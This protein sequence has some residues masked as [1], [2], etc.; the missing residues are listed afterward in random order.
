MALLDEARRLLG[1]AERLRGPMGNTANTKALLVEP[2]LASLGWDTANVEHVVRDWPLRDDSTVS[3]ALRIHDANAVF[4][5]TRAVSDSLDDYSFEGQTLQRVE[6][7]DA[8]WCVITNGLSYKVFKSNEPVKDD[9]ML[10][11]VDLGEIAQGDIEPATRLGLIGREALIDGSLELR[12]EE[13]FTDPRVREAILML[14]RDPSRTFINAMNEAIG[15][16]SVPV[17]RLRASLGRSFAEHPEVFGGSLALQASPLAGLGRRPPSDGAGPPDQGSGPEAAAESE[18]SEEAEPAGRPEPAE[19]PTPAQEAEPAEEPKPAQE[20]QVEEELAEPAAEEDEPAQALEEIADLEEA[21]EPLEDLEL[22]EPAVG[23]EEAV[24]PEEAP[25]EEDELAQGPEEPEEDAVATLEEEAAE[26][27]GDGAVEL[28]EDA[29]AEAEAEPQPEA[30]ESEPS[31]FVQEEQPPLTVFEPA[32]DEEDVNAAA[33]AW[34]PLVGLDESEG[35][36]GPIARGTSQRRR[37]TDSYAGVFSVGR[38]D[39]PLS[40]H[41]NGKPDTIV[42]MFMQL[43]EYSQSLGTDTSRRVRKQH[44]QYLNG[45]KAW[46]TLELHDELLRLDLALEPAAVRAWWS[47][48]EEH[49]DISISDRRPGETEYTLR[50]PA[51]LEEARQLIWMAYE[52]FSAPA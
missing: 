19:E 29:E 15:S 47:Q 6:N 37:W 36:D 24:E 18:G 21:V 25:A 33:R 40:E 35:R 50:D 20:P 44:I 51:Q 11:G 43:D 42:E 31:S 45:K 10:F 7:E 2:L 16:P 9:R 23:L 49:G 22:T 30:P 13:F 4:V 26:L 34:A 12:G 17:E 14:C 39:H 38:G 27:A 52:G 46:F 41:L 8:R 1:V 28:V 3:Y 5:E 48:D 32:A